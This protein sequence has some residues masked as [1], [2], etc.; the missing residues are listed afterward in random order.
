MFSLYAT[1]REYTSTLNSSQVGWY[2]RV[3]RITKNMCPDLKQYQR[4]Q[5]ETSQVHT[6]KKKRARFPRHYMEPYCMGT[7]TLAPPHPTPCCMMPPCKPKPRCMEPHCL[8]AYKYFHIFQQLSDVK[9]VMQLGIKLGLTHH[10]RS[11][12]SHRPRLHWFERPLLPSTY[13]DR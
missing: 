8:V 4:G 6:L 11:L 12:V 1:V 5:V 2:S 9:E 13:A 3:Q 10:E 7:H